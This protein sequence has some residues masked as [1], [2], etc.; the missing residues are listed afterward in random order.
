MT[1]SSYTDILV[2][3][4]SSN[5]VGYL[6]RQNDYFRVTNKNFSS[7]SFDGYISSFSR[8]IVIWD[9]ANRQ[10]NFGA[11]DYLSIIDADNVVSNYQITSVTTDPDSSFFDDSLFPQGKGRASVTAVSG[12]GTQIVYTAANNF[13]AGQ[14]VRIS[15]VSPAG[16]SSESALI[17][18]RNATTFTVAG[19]QTGTATLTSASVELVTSFLSN[20]YVRYLDENLVEQVYTIVPVLVDGYPVNRLNVI[21]EDWKRKGL[22][23][24]GWLLT[25]SGNAIF[26]NIAVR[27]EIEATSGNFLGNLTVNNGTMK[28]GAGVSRTNDYSISSVSVSS[29]R[30]LLTTDSTTESS[31][32]A[33]GDTIIVSDLDLTETGF[34]DLNGIFT[35]SY[36]SSTQVGYDFKMPDTGPFATSVG[37]VALESANDGIFINT[38]NYWY[39]DG[40]FKFGNDTNNVNW[41]TELLVP[42]LEISGDV[43]ANSGRIG[44]LDSTSTA[45]WTIGT[46]LIRSGVGTDT[47]ALASPALNFAD[48]ANQTIN[49]YAITKLVIDSEGGGLSTLYLHITVPNLETFLETELATTINT[50]EELSFAVSQYF[51]TKPILF[52]TVVSGEQNIFSTT[53][54]PNL[55]TATENRWLNVQAA[56]D[57]AVSLVSGGAEYAANPT[58]NLVVLEFWGEDYGYLAFDETITT[59]TTQLIDVLAGSTGTGN[60]FF[61]AGSE[62][63]EDAPF[64]VDTAGS[65]YSENISSGVMNANEANVVSFILD[66]HTVSISAAEPESPVGGDIWIE[67]I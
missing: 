9:K 52:K 18:S 58:A 17:V 33:I 37:Y 42:R 41:N 28:L 5:L 16:Y 47:V 6:D 30:V 54:N 65:L 48:T 60:Y 21:Q 50:A 40:T 57:Y 49:R 12:N 22:G 7:W 10:F 24:N 23:S 55:K 13:V 27:G 44:S 51:S 64:S 32:F 56:G 66:G 59:W 2:N 67:I 29:N 15:G 61:W 14:R 11:G 25:S 35:V 36:V 38:N 45:A 62:L 46:G 8:N 43:Y 31:D 1:E 19:T 20:V 34:M 63:A 3:T 53:I 39:S 26:N 4:N